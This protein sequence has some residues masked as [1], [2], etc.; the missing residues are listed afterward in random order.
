MRY[1]WDTPEY[2]DAFAT[3][4]RASGE[5]PGV[6]QVLRDLLAGYPPDAHAIDW[7][8]GGGDLTALLLDRFRHVYAVE[9]NAAQRAILTARCP[10]AQVIAGTLTSAAPPA[11]VAVGLISHVFYHVPDHEWGAHTTRAAGHLTADGALA[12]LLIGPDAGSN[13]MLEHFGA[14]P[15]DLYA[16]LA[17]ALRRHK[18]FDFSF[19]RLP[20]AIRTGSFDDTLKVARFVLCDRDEDAFSRQPTEE[21]FREYVRAHFW[22][23]RRG[24]GGWDYDVVFCLV[25]RNPWERDRIRKLLGQ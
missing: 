25:R 8:A 9:P 1:R 6:H 15:F 10:G 18:E 17:G 20:T 11:P 14:P 4:L 12:V 2:A 24:A 13:R 21:D 5:R 23:E 16:G 7:G 19:T 22:D 3:L